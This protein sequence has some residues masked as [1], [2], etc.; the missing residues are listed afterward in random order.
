MALLIIEIK[1]DIYIYII[2]VNIIV[3][4]MKIL[5]C[6]SASLLCR[7]KSSDGLLQV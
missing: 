6:C 2:Q 5:T 3:S 7:W 1:G 4:M